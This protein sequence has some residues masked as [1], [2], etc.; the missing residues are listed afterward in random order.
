[1]LHCRPMS[2]SRMDPKDA[3]GYN[4]GP[5]RSRAP[6]DDAP[7]SSYQIRSCMRAKH[8]SF[9]SDPLPTVQLHTRQAGA[10]R[11][12]GDPTSRPLVGQR[13]NRLWALGYAMSLLVQM[14]AQKSLI[15]RLVSHLAEPHLEKQAHYYRFGTPI[16]GEQFA[17]LANDQPTK[18][19]CPVPSRDV[20]ITFVQIRG[21]GSLA[22]CLMRGPRRP[23]MVYVKFFTR[24][25]V[26]SRPMP[27]F[28]RPSESC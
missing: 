7:F 27:G 17:R 24:C 9:L 14:V 19:C 8:Q 12:S 25:A 28:C 11:P 10:I 26:R 23:G 13:G 20:W 16:R 1:M 6:T 2:L 5:P 21:L 18:R 15:R 4:L 22:R 3:L